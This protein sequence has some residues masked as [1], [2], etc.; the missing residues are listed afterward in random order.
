MRGSFR[1]PFPLSAMSAALVIFVVGILVVLIIGILVGVLIV[2]VVRVLIVAI[3]V[4]HFGHLLLYRIVR[5]Y[6]FRNN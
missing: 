4:V 2:L 1:A 6:C 3:L 5:Q